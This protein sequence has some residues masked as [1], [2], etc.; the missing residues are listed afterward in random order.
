MLRLG[1]RARVIPA[2][3]FAFV[4]LLGYEVIPFAH[5]AM[6]AHIGAH[7]HSFE[8]SLGH[9]VGEH[10]H[11]GICHSDAPDEQTANAGKHSSPSHGAGSLEHRGLAALPHELTLFVPE[12]MLAG[13]MPRDAVL[14]ARVSAFERCAPPATGPPA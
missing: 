3:L 4:W 14:V 8:H 9:G 6:H 1:T 11:G 12:L 2:L 13:E 7:S 10:C 5:Q